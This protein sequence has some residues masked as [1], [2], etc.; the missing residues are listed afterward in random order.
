MTRQRSLIQRGAGTLQDFQNAETD[1][2]AAAAGLD[3]ARVTA[4]STLASAQAT[5]VALEVAKEGLRDLTIHAPTPSELPDGF[6][7]ALKYAVAERRVSEGQ[8]LGQGEAVYRLVVEDPLR[9]WANVPERYRS[10]AKLGLPVRVQAL[11]RPDQEFEGTVTRINPTVDPVSRTFQVEARIP[12]ASGLLLPGG[13]AKAWVQ[14]ERV[15]AAKVVPIESVLQY[16]GVTK[17]FVL[18]GDRA[19]E[20]QVSTGLQDASGLWPEGAWIEV[21]G[22]TEPVSENALVVTTGQTQLAEGTRVIVRDEEP[23]AIPAAEP[24]AAE[25]EAGPAAA[26]E[27]EEGDAS[28]PTP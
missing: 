22:K 27:Q 5:Q 12:N 28:R 2:A 4:R 25:P 15:D 6:D 26:G 23:E 16:A 7:G 9:L 11:S 10:Q 20:V 8:M 14:T 1:E 13:F 3:A 24:A 19:D 17:I 18:D 21:V